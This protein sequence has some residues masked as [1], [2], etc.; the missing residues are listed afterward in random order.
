[1]GTCA[2]EFGRGR[3]A[4]VAL[5]RAFTLIELLIVVVVL[6]IAGALVIPSMTQTGALRVQGAV[7]TVVADLVF[8]Q[9]DALAYQSRRVVWF[10][11]VA[12]RDTDTGAWTYVP[13]NGYVVAEVNGAAVD[14]ATDVMP[15]P[16]DTN[17]PF[18]RDFDDG[19]FGDAVIG[20]IN[21]NDGALLIFD[22]LGGPV[23][24]L[25]GDEP[26]V[27]GQLEISGSGSVF[28]IDVAAY[29]G[30]VTVTRVEDAA[31]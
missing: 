2:N 31:P 21:F 29:T 7:R 26:G 23:A 20:N 1:M 14:L 22:E 25:D 10:G 15:D 6:G 11:R 18:S 27:G 19:Q 17:R 8:V 12:Q 24:E 9:S 13:G 5:G 28:E 30:R 16:S 3:C 4:P